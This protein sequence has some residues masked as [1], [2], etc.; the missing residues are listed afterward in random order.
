M[1]R[2]RPL[3]ALLAAL[4][5]CS[6]LTVPAFAAFSDVPSDAWY[7]QDVEDVQD[8]G[9]L[10]GVGN[11]KFSPDGKLTLAQAITLAARTSAKLNNETIPNQNGNPWYQGYLEYADSKGICKT[12]EFGTSYDSNC[13]RLTMAKL[14]ARVLPKATEKKLNTI[15][16]IPD[17]KRSQDTEEVYGLY[18]QGVLTGS[19]AAGTFKPYHGISRAE[20]AAIL[21]R[22]IHPEK[23]KTIALK[24]AP[25]VSASSDGLA[26]PVAK[27][28]LNRL[29]ATISYDPVPS[30]D[31]YDF[32]MAGP[33]ESRQADTSKLEWE[34]L[35]V[36]WDGDP[37]LYMY[38]WYYEPGYYYFKVH[39]YQGSGSHVKYSPA[40]N[41][42]MVTIFP[43]AATFSAEAIDA[44]DQAFKAGEYEV[45]VENLEFALDSLWDHSYAMK[46]TPE[47][48]EDTKDAVEKVWNRRAEICAAWQKQ[49]GCPLAVINQ[50]LDSDTWPKR[51]Y[52]TVRN[53]TG[54]EVIR[55]DM[56]FGC[57]NAY[58][59]PAYYENNPH[60]SNIWDGWDEYGI[61]A[62]GTEESYSDLSG[63]YNVYHVYNVKIN[64]VAYSDGTYWKK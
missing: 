49:I 52:T 64:G 46:G 12:G 58:S 59:E 61:P 38:M 29:L 36:T 27:A 45:A 63:F 19:D 44:A 1:K 39:A 34:Q 51:Y 7:A 35:D 60:N 5:L 17:L 21:N 2:N 16:A 57:Y 48:K 30:A 41:A 6:V 20:A 15:S 11:G 26:A 42:V 53:L 24:P 14:F 47:E 3:A 9:V 8:F 40:S 23:R 28:S 4:I 50:Y 18:E 22:V 37:N 62:Y 13:D 43:T 56:Q 10:Q 55:Y 33:Y 54:K 32:Y 25:A 31:N